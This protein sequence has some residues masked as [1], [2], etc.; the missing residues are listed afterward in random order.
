MAIRTKE[1]LITA[2]TTQLGDNNSD[3]AIAIIEDVTDTLNELENKSNG[4]GTDWKA[5]YEQNDKAWRDKYISRFS[6]GGTGNDDELP[7][8]DSKKD[9]SYDNLFK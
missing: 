6:K 4:D 5:K 8:P 2:I 1:E 7:K 9:Y 3:E